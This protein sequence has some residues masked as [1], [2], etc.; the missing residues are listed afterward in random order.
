MPTWPAR[1][2]SRQPGRTGRPGG[3]VTESWMSTALKRSARRR[4]ARKLCQRP[5]GDGDAASG[6]HAG[7]GLPAWLDAP[8]ELAARTVAAGQRRLEHRLDAERQRASGCP[9][10][11]SAD[12]KV[13][14]VRAFEHAAQPLQ[15]SASGWPDAADRH[16]EPRPD[17]FV[18]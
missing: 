14:E 11:G 10:A 16:V 7:V 15:D 2:A 17:L 12:F 18:A 1:Q 8:V 9:A 5:F 6:A 4:P 13:S 3:V